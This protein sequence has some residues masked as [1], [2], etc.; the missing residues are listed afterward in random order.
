MLSGP[1]VEVLFPL[2]SAVGRTELL[3]VPAMQWVILSPLSA[4]SSPCPLA[5]IRTHPRCSGKL[6]SSQVRKA[7]QASGRVGIG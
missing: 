4:S 2:N 1:K 6:V 3:L 7:P 5:L